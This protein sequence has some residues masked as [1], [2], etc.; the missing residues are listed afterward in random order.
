VIERQSK[1]NLDLGIEAVS[2]Y[3]DA[4][5]PD[6]DGGVYITPCEQSELWPALQTWLAQTDTVD[7]VEAECDHIRMRGLAKGYNRPMSQR[8]KDWQTIVLPILEAYRA[9]K[10]AQSGNEPDRAA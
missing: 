5:H 4:T 3:M 2:V 7:S 6:S 10:E 8:R 1:I 9:R